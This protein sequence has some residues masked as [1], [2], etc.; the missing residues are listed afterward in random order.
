M[1]DYFE[2][3]LDGVPLEKAGPMVPTAPQS[4]KRATKPWF[5]RI[6]GPNPKRYEL[7]ECKEEVHSDQ[8]QTCPQPPGPST[9][10]RPERW[11]G[12]KWEGAKLP[13]LATTTKAAPKAA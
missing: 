3:Y 4:A 5:L 13:L 1:K 8:E 10:K 9:D 6:R 7:R 2:G 12:G 11:G